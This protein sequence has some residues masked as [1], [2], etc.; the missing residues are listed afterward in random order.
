MIFDGDCEKVL[1]SIESEKYT[2]IITDPPYG[3]S[4]MDN[5]WDDSLPSKEVW[6]KLLRVTKKGGYLFAF[7]SPKT[8]HRLACDIE[9]AGWEI[10]DCISWVYGQGFP[11]S[12]NISKSIDNKLG[13]EREVVGYWKPTGTARPTKN[14]KGHSASKT[15]ASIDNYKPKNTYLPI[16]KAGSEEAKDFEGFGTCLKPA[17]EPIIVAMK[18][19]HNYVDNALKIGI[20]GLNIDNSRIDSPEQKEGRFPANFIMS[21]SIDCTDKKCSKYCPVKELDEQTIKINGASRFFYC[22]KP[23]KKDRD[24]N[25]HPTVKPIELMEYLVKMVKQPKGRTYV[26]DPFGGSGTTLIACMNQDVK[27][28]TI[29]RNEEYLKIIKRRYYELKKE[30]SKSKFDTLSKNKEQNRFKKLVNNK[31]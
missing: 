11:K 4:F 10:K 14:G 1:D 13:I 20:S 15:T 24:F 5:K 2:S 25:T 12:M 17:F 28:D 16:T 27:C 7:G 6:K 22:S 29:E 21:H 3:I 23:S 9:D 26:L 19:N 30:Q 8:F 31:K 18:P